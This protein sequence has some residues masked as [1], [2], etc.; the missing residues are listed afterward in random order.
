MKNNPCSLKHGRAREDT[1]GTGL[2]FTPARKKGPW[3]KYPVSS[4]TINVP[5]FGF[6]SI[7]IKIYR[8]P[9]GWPDFAALRNIVSWDRYK[10][11]RYTVF[12]AWYPRHMKY[13]I[14]LTY[15]SN[16]NNFIA[17]EAA[18][19]AYIPVGFYSE[20]ADSRISK[21]AKKFSR[22]LEIQSPRFGLSVQLGTSTVI[23]FAET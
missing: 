21:S 15:D 6:Q 19:N 20:T 18:G 11:I 14:S 8:A 13:V 4:E 5:Q 2:R 23:L 22:R 10:L 9:N 16:K 3:R 17:Y 12:P 1:D 7:T